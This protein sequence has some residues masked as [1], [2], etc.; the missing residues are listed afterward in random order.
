M[1]NI[2]NIRVSIDPGHLQRLVPFMAV[3]DIRYYLNGVC[4]EKAET[5]GIYLIATDGHTMGVIHDATGTIE[6]ADSV[7]FRVGPGLA[8]A[9][10]VASNKLHRGIKYRLLVQ[11]QRVKIACDFGSEGDAELFV[12]AGRSL[13]EGKFPNW[14]KVVPDFAKLKPG[15]GDCMNAHYLARLAKIATDKR[16]QGISLW[17]A[18]PEKAIVARVPRVPE[19]VIV[20]MPMRDS[21]R[22]PLLA[23]KGFPLEQP[24]EEMLPE[25]ESA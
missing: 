23:F 17:Q 1:S 11:G 9:T 2:E 14:R 12:Q 18:E 8:P 16:F 24:K 10:K 20:F 4:V 13:I 5:G 6:G 15:F 3:H 25:L 22:D 19:M 7:I 21:V